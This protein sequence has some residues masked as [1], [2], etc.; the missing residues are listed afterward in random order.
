MTTQ[1]SDPPAIASPVN[2]KR[3]VMAQVS[4]CQGCCCGNISRGKPDVPVDWI[5]QQWRQRGL[6]KHIQLTISG[7]LGPCDLVNVVRISCKG[8]DLWLGNIRSF[9]QYSDLVD[10]AERSKTA[11]NLLPLS[12]SIAE[13]RF[14]P[15]HD[16]ASENGWIDSKPFTFFE[17][18]GAQ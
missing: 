13:L 12:K 16:I 17:A 5:K 8:S 6:L 3:T 7:C 11:G 4:L 14:N 10:W 9:E 18:E 1:S 15:F 2:T